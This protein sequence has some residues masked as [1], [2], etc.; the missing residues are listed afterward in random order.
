MKIGILCIATNR[1]REFI[2]PLIE[3][4]EAN[5]LTAHDVTIHLFTDD[6]INLKTGL[7]VEQTIIPSY[8]FPEATLYRY[9]IFLQKDYTD[10]Y[11]FYLDAD[12]RVIDTVGD[13][14]LNDIT[15]VRHPGFYH[16]GWGSNNV[17]VNS[18]AFIP[19]NMKGQYMAGGFQGGKADHYYKAMIELDAA[20]NADEARGI[21]AE[22]HDESHWNKWLTVNRKTVLDSSYCMAESIAKRNYW[23]ISH[24]KPIILALEKDFNYF[25]Q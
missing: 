18:T 3:S 8:K 15:C 22:Y 19:K 23:K 9:R 12:M 25:R 13:E 14:V 24:L 6:L 16:G 2:Q 7:K 5:F 1:Y 4:I 11:L 20:I 10:D 21:M 17:H